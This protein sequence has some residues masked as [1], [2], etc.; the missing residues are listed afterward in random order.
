M[1]DL[2]F[3]SLWLWDSLPRQPRSRRLSVWR[4]MVS[5]E[6]LHFVQATFF[7]GLCWRLTLVSSQHVYQHWGG[8]S[9]ARWNNGVGWLRRSWER[10][11][12]VPGYYG[13]GANWKRDRLGQ[14][15]LSLVHIT[16]RWT[17]RKILWRKSPGWK[18]LR[19]IWARGHNAEKKESIE[20]KQD[21]WRIN[22]WQFLCIPVRFCQIL[23]ILH[24]SRY[25]AS[26]PITS[27]NSS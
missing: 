20:K 11:Q 17:T 14:T 12:P 22:P 19:M 2:S 4:N 27:I 26:K 8:L 25:P 7:F 23:S 13:E 16:C 24:A 3:V 1:R 21:R 6:M 5:K 10:N 15:H 18:S 9:R